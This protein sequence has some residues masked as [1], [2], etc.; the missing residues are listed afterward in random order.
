MPGGF[1][2]A[3][4][5]RSAGRSFTYEKWSFLGIF[6]CLNPFLKFFRQVKGWLLLKSLEMIRMSHVVECRLVFRSL[7]NL[8]WLERVLKL[9]KNAQLNILSRLGTFTKFLGRLRSALDQKLHVVACVIAFHLFYEG[10]WQGGVFKIM[11]N[12]CF[13]VF[14]AVCVLFTKFLGRCRVVY[15]NCMKQ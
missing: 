10:G 4:G 15:I 3:L 5:S 13:L 1:Y 14:L 9:L 8:G 11:K 7:C 12:D 6:S 2:F